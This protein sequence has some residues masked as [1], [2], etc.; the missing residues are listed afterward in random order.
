MTAVETIKSDMPRVPLECLQTVIRQHMMY[1]RPCLK[2]YASVLILGRRK[3]SPHRD[4]HPR[5]RRFLL[6]QS[7]MTRCHPLMVDFRQRVSKPWSN[8]SDK[9]GRQVDS[10]VYLTN[11]ELLSLAPTALSSSA[12]LSHLSL[13]IVCTFPP[14]QSVRCWRASTGKGQGHLGEGRRMLGPHH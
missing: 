12:A 8:T 3:W 2:A 13:V 5:W 4:L 11:S 1:W 6:R 10:G 7:P 9:G 14:L